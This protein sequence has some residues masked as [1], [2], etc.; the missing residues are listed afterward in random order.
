MFDN[1]RSGAPGVPDA[2]RA[3][4]RRSSS[5][6]P[7]REIPIN[8]SRV[9]FGN[10]GTAA[11]CQDGAF[12]ALLCPRRDRQILSNGSGLPASSSPIGPAI[13]IC[14]DC[15]VG[16]LGPV[17]DVKGRVN[18]QIRDLDQTVIGNPAHDLIRL[19]LSL[20]MAARGAN[21]PG[22]TTATDDRS[23]WPG[24]IAEALRGARRQ[25][26]GAFEDRQAC[27]AAGVAA[28][29]EEPCQ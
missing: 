17:A 8:C 22:L 9:A 3:P 25:A 10:P 18:V 11:P 12:R 1:R 14:G 15:H 21:L 2:R 24:A 6:R 13:W 16:N 20:A 5:V 4:C 7:L 19:G 28:S 26:E 23:T 27:P 29:L